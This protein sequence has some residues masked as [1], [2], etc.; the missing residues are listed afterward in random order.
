MFKD[1]WVFKDLEDHKDHKGFK[2]QWVFKDHKDLKDL[3]VFKV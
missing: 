3:R 2:D 1:Q